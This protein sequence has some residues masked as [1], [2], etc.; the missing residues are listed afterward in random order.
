MIVGSIFVMMATI[1]YMTV[2]DDLRHTGELIGVTALLV[3]GIAFVVTGR[4]LSRF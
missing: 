3:V 1:G 2:A 4:I